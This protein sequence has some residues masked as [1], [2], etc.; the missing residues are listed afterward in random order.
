MAYARTFLANYSMLAVGDLGA[1]LLIFWALVRMA[2][3][4]GTDL[5]GD[6]AFAA[7]LAAYFAILVNQGLDVYGIRET[8]ANPSLLANHAGNILGLRLIAGVLASLILVLVVL[9]IEKPDHVK[10]L[11]LLNG[12]L[13]FSSALSLRWV[14]QAKEQ[15]KYLAAAGV[16]A[17][18]VY[19][20]S[21]LLFLKRPAQYYWIPIF[22]F[23]GEALATW[24]L[25]ISAAR[26]YGF[27]RPNFRFRQ[28]SNMLKESLPMGVSISLGMIMFQFDLVLLGFMKPAAEVGFY[29][30]AYKVILF[31]SAF[32]FLYGV[33]IFPGIA[34]CKK[35]P[36]TLRPIANQSLRYTMM[37]TIP[38]AA[39]GYLLAGPLMNFI[40]G[41]EFAGGAGALQILLWII[42]LMTA[43]IVYRATLL[44][45]GFERQEL[46][47]AL[48]ATVTN[49]GLNL[50]LIPQFS[51]MGAAVATLTAEVVFLLLACVQVA[52]K[53]TAIPFIRH[54]WKPLAACLPMAA[55]VIGLEGTHIF[56]RILAGFTVYMITGWGIGLYRFTEIREAVM[57]SSSEPAEA[58]AWQRF[59]GTHS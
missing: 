56:V 9:L 59:W 44:T 46:W 15:M 26:K 6:I 48:G 30:A 58:T 47:I 1:K 23:S 14:F 7:A 34:R 10:I 4:L 5:F 22:Q 51:L 32:V 20:G 11:L 21:I 13:Y 36:H 12:F 28:W 38:L 39:G 42:P 37:L 27:F 50:L 19:A 33:N 24:V 31:F 17:Q 49:V 43:R 40:Y 2:R 18:C 54:I 29:S 41:P 8:V 35:E 52:G 16:V 25:Y 57:L 3:V 53:V 55:A 45:H